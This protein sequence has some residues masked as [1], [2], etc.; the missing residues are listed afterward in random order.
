[1]EIGVFQNG[2]NKLIASSVS[3]GTNPE[4]AHFTISTSGTYYIKIYGYAGAYS[5][6][7]PYKMMLTKGDTPFYMEGQRYRLYPYAFYGRLFNGT[8][9]HTTG[10]AYSYG[11]KDSISGYLSKMV[12]A[13]QYKTKPQDNWNDYSASHPRPGRWKS[14]Y[15]NGDRGQANWAGIDCSGL[16]WY[17]AK[18][19]NISYAIEGMSVLDVGTEAIYNNSTAVSLSS[20]EIGDVYVK[21]GD[22]VVFLSKLA[23]VYEK[24]S[25][26]IHAWSGPSARK[27]QET[28][29][30]AIT[31]N[32]FKRRA[33][34]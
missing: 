14:E 15:D 30:G 11:S 23:L 24:D 2:S 5:T 6:I 4:Q 31:Y 17:A 33:L 29:I 21:S 19:S 3:G 8:E 7:Y 16:I 28:S 34:N 25:F 13:D 12:E 27:V 22:H 9:S 20:A 26:I 18:A 32:Q 10:V 1:M